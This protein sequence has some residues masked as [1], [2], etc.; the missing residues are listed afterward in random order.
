MESVTRVVVAD[1]DEDTRNLVQLAFASANWSV[2]EAVDAATT[3]RLVAA[4][5]PAVL[6]VDVDL[7]GGGG[8]ATARV[9]RSQPRTAGIGVVVLT[10]AGGGAT[11]G[12]L[13]DGAVDGVLERPLD[14][15]TLFAMVEQVL[16]RDGRA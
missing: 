15:F 1:P 12:S 10:R 11:D 2:R 13:A 4:E 7:P 5:V 14:A 8:H 16:G 9:L 3:V 6:I